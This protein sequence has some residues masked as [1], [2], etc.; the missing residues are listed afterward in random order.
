MEKFYC[1]S[2]TRHLVWFTTR[3]Q[4]K[5]QTN[6][7]RNPK[8]C[9]QK[10][11]S[12]EG[13]KIIVRISNGDKIWRQNKRVGFYCRFAAVALISPVVSNRT[14]KLIFA[15]Q[16]WNSL[17]FTCVSGLYDCRIFK[18]LRARLPAKFRNVERKRSEI[19]SN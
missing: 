16:Y 8:L 15:V 6:N 13:S 5:A 11:L 12:F 18:I 3:Q 10:A 19:H 7:A 17:V 14:Q 1:D 9:H 2:A 4:F